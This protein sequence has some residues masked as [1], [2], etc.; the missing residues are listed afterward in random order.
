MGGHRTNVDIRRCRLAGD[1][2]KL[3]T[4]ENCGQKFVQQFEEHSTHVC[5]VEL[6]RREHVEYNYKIP[7]TDY[8]CAMVK[9]ILYIAHPGEPPLFIA[10][11][12]E[13]G[14]QVVPLKIVSTVPFEPTEF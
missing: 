10:Y 2:V 7:G 13:N 8:S 3:N 14:F 12:D 5:E 4:C 1:A 6:K 11:N 9:N